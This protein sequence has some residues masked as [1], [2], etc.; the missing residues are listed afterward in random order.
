MFLYAWCLH[1]LQVHVKIFDLKHRTL[2]F[3]DQNFLQR[4][5]LGTELKKQL[6]ISESVPPSSPLYQASFQT[7][8]FEISGPN[9]E[10]KFILWTGIEKEIVVFRISTP[11]FSF[12]PSYILSKALWNF[13]PKKGILGTEFEETIVEFRICTPWI[14]L[15][16][17]CHSKQSTLKF[18]LR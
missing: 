14:P 9:C 8:Y 12:I 13:G 4:G 1:F 3:C 5:I 7:K 11:E 10:K 16:T 6:P 18:C 15:C 17:E 2:K